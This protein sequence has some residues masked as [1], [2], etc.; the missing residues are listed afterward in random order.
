MIKRFMLGSVSSVLMFSVLFPS[1]VYADVEKDNTI[2]IEQLIQTMPDE[3]KQEEGARGFV[4]RIYKIALGRDYD[5]DGL[6]FWVAQLEGQQS[7]GLDVF[8]RI[9]ACPEFTDKNLNNEQYLTILYKVFF[10][11]DPDEEGFYYWFYDL[12]EGLLSKDDVL[13][14]FANSEEWKKICDGYGILTGGLA[15]PTYPADYSDPIDSFVARLYRGCLGRD[16]DDDGLKYWSD[17]LRSKTITGRQAAYGFFTSG[18]FSVI[19]SELDST[20]L[21][22]RFY[23]VFLNRVPDTSGEAFWIESIAG[24]S[25]PTAILFNGF[26]DSQEFSDLCTM[27]GI[28]PGESI[29]IKTVTIDEGY[30][31]FKN[32]YLNSGI[33]ILNGAVGQSKTTY[34]F[35]NVQGGERVWEE[36]EIP[37]EDLKA[38]K[39]FADTYFDPS[40]TPGEKAA[41]TL[42]WVHHNMAYGGGTSNYAVSA[43]VNR[44]G[45]CAQYNGCMVELLCWLGYD[46]CLIQGARGRSAP[47]A[48]HFWCE[49]YIN[50]ETYV[51]EAGNTKDGNW[52]Y[53][54][55]PYSQTRKFI[56]CGQVMG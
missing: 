35:C 46:A 20:K 54:V 29:R 26:S 51:V 5:E 19:A 56:V 27:C 38:L 13:N 28:D 41:F 4:A 24:N 9:T 53:F 3:T 55:C 23:E 8:K 22:G 39:D 37:A 2:S 50:G 1:A 18:E 40:W 49:V 21:V 36:R 30:E 47:G 33:D 31:R 32:Y 42:Y 17:N 44:S 52:N 7:T 43:L 45:Q 12:E 15:I 48:Q 6:K 16:P 10:D 25:K 34:K 14:S 11:R